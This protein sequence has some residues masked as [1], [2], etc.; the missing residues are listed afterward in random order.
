MPLRAINPAAG[1]QL[2]SFDEAT[3]SEV[4]EALDCN[5]TEFAKWRARPIAE[6]AALIRR[7]TE[8]LRENKEELA[9]LATLEKGK[10][11]AESEGPTAIFA[12]ETEAKA[13]INE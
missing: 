6:R 11:L 9:R 2:A 3:E 10:I 4:S 7:P 12:P 1:K 5:V 13:V 8:V